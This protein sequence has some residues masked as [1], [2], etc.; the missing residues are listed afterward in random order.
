MIA[1]NTIEDPPTSYQ[2]KVFVT[3]TPSPI[4]AVITV[5]ATT[6]LVTIPVTD[7]VESTPSVSPTP[8]VEILHT[9]TATFTPDISCTP[10]FV[11]IS[12]VTIPDG[13]VI[14]ANAS[15]IKTW[16][17]R[18]V[19][20]C[21]W[22]EGYTLA[23]VE[24][25]RMGNINIVGLP[26]TQ[27]DSITEISV[28]LV[29]PYEA[30]H[31]V[32]I[33]QLRNP[34]GESF[35][36]NLTVDIDVPMPT[37]TPSPTK[38]IMPTATPSPTKTITPTAPPSPTKTITPTVTSSPTATPRPPTRTPAPLATC[39]R[40]FDN[41][42]TVISNFLNNKDNQPDDLNAWLKNC[43]LI[44]DKIGGTITKH[45]QNENST[46]LIVVIHREIS[47]IVTN[48]KLL[49]YHADNE[50]YSL[51]YATNIIGVVNILAVEDI[52]DDNKLELVWTYNDC[53][54]HTCIRTLLVEQWTGEVYQP[55]I[56]NPPSIFSA[57]YQITDT[58]NEGSGLEIVGYGGK[59]K[60]VG[61]G[62]QRLKTV[63][64]I[65]PNG[66]AYQ[67]FDDV[68][69]PPTCLYHQIIDAN[70]MFNEG[71]YHEAII[72]YQTALTDDSLE[73][74]HENLD[75]EL[76]LLRDFARYRL[77][78]AY[79]AIDQ[80]D[81]ATQIQNNIQVPALHGCTEVFLDEFGDSNDLTEACTV[82]LSCAF[83]H[84]D[85]W[86]FLH[87]WGYSNP[88]FTARDLCPIH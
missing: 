54:I 67:L 16:H 2:E 14:E 23:F 80:F 21:H 77:A 63:T 25:Q 83:N 60:S 20:T 79:T 4:A 29:A 70:T 13:T 47:P 7:M 75:N 11:F 32:G 78:V 84:P 68:Y 33:W 10:N 59:I 72:A 24:G 42:P 73:A 86:N 58:L 40:N 56:I 5:T 26:S 51:A 45:I 61:A 9:P 19:G 1:C 44:S 34:Q 17:V 88:S 87:D 38:T 82:T 41:Y 6:L 15:F 31:Y 22:G 46:D 18:N 66:D 69:N 37:A 39:Q 36:G 50:G 43:Q 53:G 52:N 35:G 85:S 27:S 74:C 48:G 49:I 65:S 55:W 64:Y 57:E 81:K 71:N 12:D 8:T 30:G 76:A 3:V 28:N 62:P